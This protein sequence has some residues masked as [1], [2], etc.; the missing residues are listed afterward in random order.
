MQSLTSYSVINLRPFYQVGHARIIYSG[1]NIQ[2]AHIYGALAGSCGI[3]LADGS[4]LTLLL[5]MSANCAIRS[6]SLICLFT[7]FRMINIRRLIQRINWDLRLIKTRL[8]PNHWITDNLWII[9]VDKT[10]HKSIPL[11]HTAQ[12][13]AHQSLSLGF[14]QAQMAEMQHTAY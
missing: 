4:H 9:S 10:G 5:F 13:S 6:F 12:L 8:L 7:R 11:W 1:N 2:L 14:L 3:L